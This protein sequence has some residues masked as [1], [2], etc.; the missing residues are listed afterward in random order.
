[1]GTL[2]KRNL[3]WWRVVRAASVRHTRRLAAKG[4]LPSSP[5][6]RGAAS[7]GCATKRK[8]RAMGEVRIRS[9]TPST[10]R[11]IYSCHRYVVCP[12]LHSCEIIP[13]S[14]SAGGGL[15]FHDNRQKCST[16]NTSAHLLWSTIDTNERNETEKTGAICVRRPT[17]GSSIGEVGACSC[18]TSAQ[19]GIATPSCW[20]QVEAN[21]LEN[22]RAKGRESDVAVCRNQLI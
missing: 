4:I 10:I 7:H 16:L 13:E 2:L 22:H 15:V 5:R 18:P 21:K 6:P 8:M 17:C 9:F 20:Q 3:R 1:L 12:T 14:L 19:T 11:S